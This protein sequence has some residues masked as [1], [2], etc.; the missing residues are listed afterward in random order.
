MASWVQACMRPLLS[1]RS[2]ARGSVPR[3]RTVDR[4]PE[5]RPPGAA[6]RSIPGPAPR[7]TALRSPRAPGPTRCLAI[8]A[9]RETAG[10]PARGGR[11]SAR[12]PARRPGSRASGPTPAGC[13][14][15]P[16]PG[17]PGARSRTSRVPVGRRGSARR[18]TAG[19]RPRAWCNTASMDRE[20]GPGVCAHER[21]ALGHTA[22]SGPAT[23][24][25]VT[26]PGRGPWLGGGLEGAPP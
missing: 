18:G 16:P 17:P 12:R 26:T 9:T 20:C 24:A 23:P 11:P 19:P 7:P 2:A 13:P 3:S 8:R 14:A 21:R 1:V 6:D 5:P 25:P 4:S 10:S 15:A 22:P